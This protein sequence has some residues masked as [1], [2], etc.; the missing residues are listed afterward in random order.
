MSTDSFA[1]NVFLPYLYDFMLISDRMLRT[2]LSLKEY[3]HVQKKFETFAIAE[4][5]VMGKIGNIVKMSV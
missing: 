1:S 4:L 2:C 3:T 5:G